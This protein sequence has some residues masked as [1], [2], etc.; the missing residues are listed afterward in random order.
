MKR[1]VTVLLLAL[2]GFSVFAQSTAPIKNLIDAVQ[3]KY[4]V[5]F[6]YDPGIVDGVTTNISTL[7]G[8][9]LRKD[10]YT[11]FAT[12][13]IDWEIKRN[14][15]VLSRRKVIE[16]KADTLRPAE[17]SGD[18]VYADGRSQENLN[19]IDASKL[20]SGYS[21]FSTPDVVKVLQTLP[22]VASGSELMSGLYVHGGT[23]DDNLYLLDGV[24]LYQVC[25]LAGLF[26]SFNS[27][28]VE[29]ASFYKS[30][31]PAR[32]GG[33]LSSVVDIE[34]RSGD[35]D[36]YHGSFSVG[37]IDGR[38]NIG[39]PIVKG[40]TSF[41]I[42]AH[43]SWLDVVTIPA[44]AIMN[45][46]NKKMGERSGFG[47]FLWDINGNITHKFSDDNTLRLNL[48]SGQ[49]RMRVSLETL[50]SA[51]DLFSDVSSSKINWGN[52]LASLDWKWK[53]HDKVSMRSTLYYTRFNG[54]VS[55]GAK[56]SDD[57]NASRIQDIGLKSDFLWSV[58]KRHLIHF[59][60][61]V[62]SHFYD[63]NRNSISMLIV[64]GKKVTGGTAHSGNAYY[65]TEFSAYIEDEMELAD[66]VCINAG[67]RYAGY[68]TGRKVY[69]SIEPRAAVNFTV[70]PSIDIYAS[71]T[72]MSQFNHQVFSVYMDLPSNLWLPTTEIIGPMRSRQVEA[73]VRAHL[74]QNMTLSANGYWKAMTGLTE[75]IGVSSLFPQVDKWEEQFTLGKG[76]A[77]GMELQYDWIT[78]KD[79]LKFA[80]TLSWSQRYFSQIW[81]GWYDDKFDNRHKI[82]ISYSR[83]FSKGFDAYI[84]WIW[85][86]GNRMTVAEYLINTNAG[87]SNMEF[88]TKPNNLKLP[89]YHRMDLGCNWRRTT[90]RGNES[91][92]NISIYN[93]YCRMN[94][95]FATVGKQDN[96]NVLARYYGLIPIVPSFSYTLKF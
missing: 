18:K 6:V 55:Y 24:P 37:L 48:Y 78:A 90:K 91:I 44:L 63:V 2:Y 81:K 1:I 71:Y 50:P 9:N 77:W 76:R 5:N 17:I 58:A 19:R 62:Q 66:W 59:G 13:D 25:H 30:G 79:N 11:I 74:P 93:V 31:F 61:S 89:D 26:S 15:V 10:L 69:H 67:L 38:F 23:G 56:L 68:Q 28:V 40:K 94:P 49:D 4:G 60:A 33:R 70:H 32:Y 80:Y 46:E 16:M 65:G 47:Y 84:G 54:K 88:Y 7:T 73:G 3:N 20:M 57:E 52:F 36:E 95:F 29:T 64:D 86:T 45:L 87:T 21:F 22:G 83:K 12:T 34:T 27:D 53:F 35:F 75:Y 43:T 51:D 82:S 85:H 8:R 42:A 39:G 96:G 14:Y 41:N 92:W 72:E